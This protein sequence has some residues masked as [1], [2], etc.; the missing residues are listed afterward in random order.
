MKPE[1]IVI[2]PPKKYDIR[3]EYLRTFRAARQL[4]SLKN[5]PLESWIGMYG[6]DAAYG[7]KRLHRIMDRA[8]QNAIG[9]YFKHFYFFYLI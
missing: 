1:E 3:L 8:F 4:R 5:I 9:A 7:T 2:I 6:T